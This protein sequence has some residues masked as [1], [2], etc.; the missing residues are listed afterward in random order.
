[1][2]SR[3]VKKKIL[4]YILEAVQFA[5]LAIVLDAFFS[6]KLITLELIL[7]WLVSGL[8]FALLFFRFF[9]QK[10]EQAE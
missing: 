7:Q 1:M 2:D 3:M 5:A 4:R 8:L 10:E 6:Q 9:K